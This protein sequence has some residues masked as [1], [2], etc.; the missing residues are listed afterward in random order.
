MSPR[1]A[2]ASPVTRARLPPGRPK[3]AAAVAV[4]IEE[5]IAASGWP[6][7]AVVGTEEALA[8]RL[9]VGRDVL[10]QAVGILEARSVARMRPGR[11][12]G[13]VALDPGSDALGAA[14]AI[15]LRLSGAGS[16]GVAEAREVVEVAAVEMAADRL[17]E[18]CLAGIRAALDLEA[19][20]NADAGQVHT[21]IARAG[22]NPVLTAIVDALA[23]VGG[24]SCTDPAS[25][26]EHAAIVEAVV[27]GDR[28]LAARRM[29]DHLGRTAGGR[30]DAGGLGDATRSGDA[31]GIA[32]PPRLPPLAG[33]ILSDLAARPGAA[34]ACIGS[35]SELLARYGA[36]RAALREA[37]RLLESY[38][39]GEMRRGRGGGLIVREPAGAEVTAALGRHVEVRNAGVVELFEARDTLEI[40]A[41]RM[42][43][44]RLD[45]AGRRRLEAAATLRGDAS[46]ADSAHGFHVSVAE[47]SGN[48]TV[49]LLVAALV[50]LS[51]ARL[52]R[53]ADPVEREA[54]RAQVAH[55][56]RRIAEA[57]LAGDVA[58][59]RRRMRLHLRALECSSA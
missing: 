36:S 52:A 49:S 38:G 6:A 24:A 9:G 40:A 50:A 17:G 48:E 11:G 25:T 2:I 12:G 47:L 5:E 42:A 57:I 21:A 20:G 34:G 45:S 10:R 14:I 7:G 18:D 59:G 4:A 35:E 13:L 41:L 51:A 27:A 23:R 44:L 22:S 31:G 46:F 43:A 15:R 58:L 32:L 16:P 30:G 8:A 39:A 19:A 33:R 56:H 28:A 37:V 53:S 3:R 29:H 1:P 54:N 26:R 55:A